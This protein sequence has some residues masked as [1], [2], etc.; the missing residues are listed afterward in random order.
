MSYASI[1]RA[2]NGRVITVSFEPKGWGLPYKELHDQTP[3]SL[4]AMAVLEGADNFDNPF[5]E[6][7]QGLYECRIV[8]GCELTRTSFSLITRDT[9]Q[10]GGKGVNK[11]GRLYLR[12]TSFGGMKGLQRTR[13][14]WSPKSGHI[15]PTNDSDG[16]FAGLFQEG[17]PVPVETLPFEKG[18]N[19][20][21]IWETHGLDPKYLSGYYVEEHINPDTDNGIRFGGR[22]CD[23]DFVGY[24]RFGVS[25]VRLPSNLGIDRV[26]SLPPYEP[27]MKISLK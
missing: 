5:A 3:L 27:D 12:V 7:M 18:D 15:V 2:K 13:Y 11:K 1:E 25:L 9:V 8:N 26:A 6:S 4:Y 20:K 17:T 14:V 10:E 21:Q 16:T 23:P 22:G 19:A 24:G